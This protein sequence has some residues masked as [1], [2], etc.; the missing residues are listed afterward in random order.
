MNDKAQ[1]MAALR[2]E[3]NRW[4]ELL[5]G[6]SEEQITASNRIEKLSIK[7]IIAHLT[8]WQKI[9]VARMEAARFDRE[10]EYPGGLSR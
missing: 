10:P 6:F 7:D 9:S 3:F 5:T 8:A 4:E 2:E 1:I